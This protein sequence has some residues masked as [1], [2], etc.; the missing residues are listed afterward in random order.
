M[1]VQLPSLP[2][3]LTPLI[4]VYFL[5]KWLKKLEP[6]MNAVLIFW[7]VNHNIMTMTIALWPYWDSKIVRQSI[8]FPGHRKFLIIALHVWNKK[9]DSRS[10]PPIGHHVEVGNLWLVG[11]GS[12]LWLVQVLRQFVTFLRDH[13]SMTCTSKHNISYMTCL[14]RHYLIYDKLG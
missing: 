11:V 3:S 12:F 6:H 4:Y 9:N 1:E 8:F 10:K 7:W 2:P 14:S 13:S 5:S